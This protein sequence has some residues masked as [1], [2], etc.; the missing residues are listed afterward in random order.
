MSGA[1]CDIS[2]IGPFPVRTR[3]GPAVLPPKAQCQC[4]PR[5]SA[6]ALGR[7]AQVQPLP[8]VR[9]SPLR[10]VLQREEGGGDCTRPKAGRM[11]VKELS[12]AGFHITELLDSKTC[13]FSSVDSQ[14]WV[15]AQGAG[16]GWASLL[17]H[18]R[19]KEF[20]R[21]GRD[22]GWLRVEPG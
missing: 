13:C 6:F 8:A 16:M 12:W 22:T 1:P 7:L 4:P 19:R 17:G 11:R 14:P 10:E 18:P 21:I 15:S 9:A 5:D 3:C 2:Q 20:L